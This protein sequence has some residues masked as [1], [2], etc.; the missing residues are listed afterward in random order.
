MNSASREALWE[1]SLNRYAA[2][3]A[4]PL[5]LRLQDEFGLNVNVLLWCGWC[6]RYFGEIPRGPLKTAVERATRWSNEV[7]ARLRAARRALKSPPQ[8]EA[9]P[10]SA[11][12][13]QVQACEIAA[14]K[15]EQQMLENIASQALSPL[16]DPA[17]AEQRLR[18]NFAAYGRLV[19]PDQDEADFD[20]LLDELAIIMMM[21]A[22][23]ADCDEAAHE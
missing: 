17:G 5:L 19:R 1:W 3:G 22:W 11:L 20:A 15:I 9:E 8:V 16:A 2:E 7:T 10:V 13:A 21:G 18:R 6:A 4:A 23:A 12:R 14:E